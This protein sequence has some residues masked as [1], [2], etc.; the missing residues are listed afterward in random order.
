MV[1]GGINNVGRTSFDELLWWPGEG[2]DE[3]PI[4]NEDGVSYSGFGGMSLVFGWRFGGAGW[5]DGG[6]G[7]NSGEPFIGETYSGGNVF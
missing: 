4:S 6:E 3:D 5:C 2:S 1:E 7:K